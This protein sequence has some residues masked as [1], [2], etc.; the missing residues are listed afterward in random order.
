MELLRGLVFQKR[1]TSGIDNVNERW[2]MTL[3]ACV[4]QIVTYVDYK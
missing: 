1:E 4:I 3:C 2:V